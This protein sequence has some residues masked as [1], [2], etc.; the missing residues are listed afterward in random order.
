MPFIR[1]EHAYHLKQAV[2]DKAFDDHKV[3]SNPASHNMH[4]FDFLASYQ[5][6]HLSC[7]PI[8][9]S[10]KEIVHAGSSHFLVE[11]FL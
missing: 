2:G 5:D 11:I 4:S 1:A 10:T 6:N 8:H 9:R 7:K 3:S